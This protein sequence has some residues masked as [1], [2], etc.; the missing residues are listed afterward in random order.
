[1]KKTL[2][3]ALTFLI[4]TAVFLWSGVYNIAANDQHWAVTNSLIDILRERSIETR[5]ESIVP[6]E[7][8]EELKVTAEVAAN[9][10]EMCA[11]CHLAP[12]L[13]VTELHAGLYPQPPVFYKAQEEHDAHG[14]QNNFWVI[15]NGIKLTGMPAWGGSHSDKEIWALVAFIDKLKLTSAKEY[16]DLTADKDGH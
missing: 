9:Y 5:A 8:L 14:V 10:N 4:G 16:Q 11:G 6:P 1:M 2:L 12:G 7:N 15:K 3:L 13:E